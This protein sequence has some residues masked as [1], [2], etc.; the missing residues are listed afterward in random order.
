MCGSVVRDPVKH[1]AWHTDLQKQ[2]AALRR[3]TKTVTY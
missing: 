3:A 2:L 1:R